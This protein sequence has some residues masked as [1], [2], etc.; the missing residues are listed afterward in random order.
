MRGNE[1][2]DKMELIAPAYIEAAG[3][4]PKSRKRVW[5]YWGTIAACLCCVAAVLLVL[6]HTASVVPSDSA[7]D[8]V[9]NSNGDNS[10][11]AERTS[12]TYDSLEALLADLSGKENH[13]NRLQIKGDGSGVLSAQT[14]GHSTVRFGEY[15]YQI[16]DDG[17]IGIYRKGALI[18]T[19]NQST[20]YL[21]A[22][23]GRL[24]AIG[25]HRLNEVDLDSEYRTEVNIF[26]VSA[27]EKP[28]R[29]EH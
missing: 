15:T 8:S 7:V 1:F 21:F 14:E 22:S 16:T 25:S 23:A 3:E 18:G 17:T 12:N 9:P 26:D 10:R 4:E 2:L 19:M 11:V 5:R 27:P 6:P 20:E 28:R 13:D 24:I 29:L